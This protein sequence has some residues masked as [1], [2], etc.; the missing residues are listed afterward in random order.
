MS[1]DYS[2]KSSRSVATHK[3]TRHHFSRK[4]G[5]RKWLKYI[6]FLY[7][8]IPISISLDRNDKKHIDL[9]FSLARKTPFF[10][11][12]VQFLLITN[13]NLLTLASYENYK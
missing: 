7:P 11:E 6:F 9:G 1:N 10:E 8:P 5:N 12:I 3:E 2:K 4:I 13:K